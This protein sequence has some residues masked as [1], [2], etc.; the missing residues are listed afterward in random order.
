[1]MN[2]TVGSRPFAYQSAYPLQQGGVL[3]TASVQP[4]ALGVQGRSGHQ[5][6]H[7]PN[8]LSPTTTR[9]E[10]VAHITQRLAG[11]TVPTEAQYP[12]AQFKAALAQWVT[13]NPTGLATEGFAKWA[14]QAK[15]ANHPGLVFIQALAGKRFQDNPTLGALTTTLQQVHTQLNQ[16]S[17]VVTQPQRGWFAEQLNLQAETHS[18]AFA[19]L[20]QAI[21]LLERIPSLGIETVEPYQPCWEVKDPKQQYIFKNE[22]SDDGSLMTYLVAINPNSTSPEE[23]ELSAMFGAKN[24]IIK[25]TVAAVDNTVPV[26]LNALAA[27]Y[28][29]G[30]LEFFQ[31]HKEIEANSPTN[32]RLDFERDMALVHADMR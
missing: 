22:V 10:L 21:A 13:E 7:S 9:A 23:K 17:V 3:K 25:L 20:Q 2:L 4:H 26:L 15:Q 12:L 14:K 11:H 6:S 30:A 19:Q 18:A 8:N 31:K 29:Y 5:V 27:A 28:N 24:T 32:V 1:M 16:P